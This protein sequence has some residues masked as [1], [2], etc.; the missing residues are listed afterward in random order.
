MKIG[1]T[2]PGDGGPTL[3]LNSQAVEAEKER[4]VG[5]WKEVIGAYIQDRIP[6]EKLNQLRIFRGQR[7]IWVDLRTTRA[8]SGD[9][10]GVTVS[11]LRLGGRY[12]DDLRPDGLTYHYPRTAQSGR[13]RME[14][15]ATKCACELQ[16][17]IFVL[18]PGLRPELRWLRRAAIDSFHDSSETFEMTFLSGAL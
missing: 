12:T 6:P 5:L 7:G 14:V 16:I 9:G 10:R 3:A 4:R 8:T 13:D 1:S 15:E 18:T 17:P 11:V 2:S